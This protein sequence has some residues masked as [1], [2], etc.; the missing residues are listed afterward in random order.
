MSY[1]F[2]ALVKEGAK[3]YFKDPWHTVEVVNIILAFASIVF[4][5]LRSYEVVKTVEFMKNNKRKFLSL[6]R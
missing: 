5:A 2:S 4:F 1:F 6:A 3:N